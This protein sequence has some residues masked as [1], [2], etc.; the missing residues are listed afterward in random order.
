MFSAAVE[1]DT[2]EKFLMIAWETSGSIH[3]LFCFAGPWVLNGRPASC[4]LPNGNVYYSLY[5][6]H[7]DMPNTSSCLPCSDLKAQSTP[8]DWPKLFWMWLVTFQYSFVHESEFSL[9]FLFLHVISTVVVISGAPE[10]G[11]NRYSIIDC[12]QFILNLKLRYTQT[13]HRPRFPVDQKC[14]AYLYTCIC[15]LI[16]DELLVLSWQTMSA[17]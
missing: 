12:D 3:C 1:A 5:L 10:Y 6:C 11:V 13:Q 8:L 7:F 15:Y 14:V 16:F 9:I 2:V 17:C 4:P